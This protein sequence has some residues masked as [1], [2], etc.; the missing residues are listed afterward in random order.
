MP[1]SLDAFE[2]LMTR[3][4]EEGMT[5]VSFHAGWLDAANPWFGYRMENE[6]YEEKGKLVPSVLHP[7]FAEM[8]QAQRRW[9]ESGWLVQ[10][11]GVKP[12]QT[13]DSQWLFTQLD[14]NELAEYPDLQPVPIFA[15]GQQP[16]VTVNN[17]LFETGFLSYT[18]PEALVILTDWMASEQG[19]EKLMR[20]GEEDTDYRMVSDGVYEWTDGLPWPGT[21][22]FSYENLFDRCVLNQPNRE[23]AERAIQD[24][25]RYARP[26]E[27]L[28][29]PNKYFVATKPHSRLEQAKKGEGEYFQL[30]YQTAYEYVWGR[31]ALSDVLGAAELNKRLIE[32]SISL[33]TDWKR[34][35][36]DP[37]DDMIR[38]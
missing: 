16:P 35:A 37:E 4:K 22:F 29:I 33:L 5:P 3:A 36:Y 6:F 12:Y 38:N 17:G 11:M 1:D 10:N 8:L 26:D 31:A 24:W 15:A 19:N 13:K 30:V 32:P 7:S 25:D 18:R 27:T 28:S 23:A 9:A 34:G 14:S 21:L 2:A 20:L